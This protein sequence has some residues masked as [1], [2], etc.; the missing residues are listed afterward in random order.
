MLRVL[1]LAALLLACD[2]GQPSD[3]RPPSASALRLPQAIDACLA[4]AD[5]PTPIDRVR[6]VDG[7]VVRALTARDAKA[8]G[9]LV[10]PG[11]DVDRTLLEVASS[12]CVGPD[13]QLSVEPDGTTLSRRV[14][15]HETGGR[16][17]G[18]HELQLRYTLSG[19]EARLA[20][21]VRYGW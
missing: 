15:G 3:A 14:L 21:A 10:A 7:L 1:V 16:C 6:A 5:A 2:R 13:A 9:A 12:E 4:S 11:V 8:L 19:D 18:A 20:S 17:V